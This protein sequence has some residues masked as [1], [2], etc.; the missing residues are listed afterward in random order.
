MNKR[1]ISKF[2]REQVGDVYSSGGYFFRRDFDYVVQGVFFEYVPRGV[3]IYDFKFPLFDF[4]GVN[5]LY[6]DRLSNSPFIGKGEMS[7]KEIVDHVIT[8]PEVKRNFDADRSMNLQDL[9]Y[10]LDS[11]RIAN[12]HAH[13]IR[14][15]TLV[16][17][18]ESD[19]ASKSLDE[20]GPRLHPADV[21]DYLNLKNA[22]EKGEGAAESLL[23]NVRQENIKKLMAT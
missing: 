7:E 13:L 18:G 22:L 9:L 17:L 21:A 10:F 15:A 19:L 4:F 1:L 11:G 2:M 3:Y 6:S 14:A 16:L 12:P 5:L 8:S 20:V 23:E